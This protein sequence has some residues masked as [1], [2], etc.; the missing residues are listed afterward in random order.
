MEHLLL[1]FSLLLLL[2]LWVGNKNKA[3]NKLQGSAMFM[4]RDGDNGMSAPV[5]LL[6]FNPSAQVG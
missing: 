4:S 3:G 6:W 1:S 5:P 2:V